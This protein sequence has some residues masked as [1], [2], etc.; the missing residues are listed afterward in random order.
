[1]YSAL[2]FKMYSKKLKFFFDNF[3]EIIGGILLILVLTMVCS[4]ILSRSLLG[5]SIIWVEEVSRVLFVWAILIGAGAGI[6]TNQLVSIDVVYQKIPDRFKIVLD[7]IIFISISI[8]LFVLGYTGYN[9]MLKYMSD[10]MAMSGLP[11]GYL[12]ASV[13]VGCVVM[14]LR[15]IQKYYPVFF[16]RNYK[17]IWRANKWL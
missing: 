15:L 11:R 17:L 14:I 12:Y 8:G 16:K 3:E 4:E 5:R 13:P 1:M 9:L 2:Q 10:L 6:K 7:I